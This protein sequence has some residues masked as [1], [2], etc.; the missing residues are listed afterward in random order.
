MAS[1]KKSSLL[2]ILKIL[3]ENTD[4]THPLTYA[5]I[6]DKLYSNYG[7]EIERKTIASSIDILVEHGYDIVKCGKNGLYLGERDFEDGELLFLIDAIYS[8]KSMPSK[9]A[10]DLA[11]RLTKNFSKFK[12]KRFNHLE[13]IDDETNTDNKQI[14][15]N[16]E[17]LNEAIEQKKKVEFQYA[18]YGIDKKLKLRGEGKVYKINPYFMVNNRGK[19][20]L[21]C[22]YDKY[23]DFANYKIDYI[24]TVK[25][26]DEPVKPIEVVSGD[27]R[28]S[29]K[30]YI[31]EHIYMM[32]GKTISAKLKILKEEKINDLIDWFGQSVDFSKSKNEIFAEFKVNED[33]LIYWALQYGEFFEIVEPLETREKIKNRLKQILE[34]YN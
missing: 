33:S 11:N 2:Y 16:I 6:G 4:E 15:Y 8:S 19:Y 7:I 32:N 29:V 17:I 24:S 14:F 13:K 18:A 10:K 12:K 3:Q 34:K 27:D 26:L 22:N 28:F 21:V 31:K 5:M 20:Y 30:D 1:D 9:Y 25:I 23:N